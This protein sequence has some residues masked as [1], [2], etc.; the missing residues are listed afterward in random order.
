MGKDKWTKRNTLFQLLFFIVLLTKTSV[1]FRKKSQEGVPYFFLEV[2]G[3]FSFHLTVKSLPKDLYVTKP[4]L[5][6]LGKQERSVNT[7]L[8]ACDRSGTN[9]LPPIIS[10]YEACYEALSIQNLKFQ[11][12]FQIS[13]AMHNFF[14]SWIYSAV[15]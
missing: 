13:L 8:Q 6:L 12:E 3:Q 15:K 2:K 1:C 10:H 11:R 14:Y 7:L 9:I 5:S 4:S